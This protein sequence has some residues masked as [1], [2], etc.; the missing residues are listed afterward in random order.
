M[1]PRGLIAEDE[2]L[3]ARSLKAAL[4][5]AWPELE[6]VALAPNGLEALAEAERLQPD[7]AFLDIRMPG[8]DGLEV[9]AELADRLGEAVP[10][11]VFVTAHDEYALKAFDHAAVD[12]VL[13]PVNGRRLARAVTRLRER[14]AT[15]RAEGNLAPLIAQLRK[16]IAADAPPRAA[17]P[18]RVIRA[19]AGNTVKMIAVEDVC[20]FQAA[21]KYTTVVTREGDALIR[22]SLR[23]L[24]AQLPP[25]RFQQIHRG[26][27]VNMQEIASAVRDDAGRVSLRL[28]HRNETLPVSRVF[29]HLFRQM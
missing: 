9:A 29:A 25:D 19:G 21:D 4:A 3:L 28:R 1:K 12:Y 20:Y 13:K 5:A 24:L 23:E 27:A 6:I 16:A 8:M 7:V 10:A 17:E 26:T 2:P 11:I 22:T 18:L 14:L 15:R